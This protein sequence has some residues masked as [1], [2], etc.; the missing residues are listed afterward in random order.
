MTMSRNEMKAAM[1][2]LMNLVDG[3]YDANIEGLRGGVSCTDVI[4]QLGLIRRH[5]KTVIVLA[6]LESAEPKR[7]SLVLKR[8]NFAG[9]ENEFVIQEVHNTMEYQPGDTMTLPVVELI[10]GDPMWNVVI[11]G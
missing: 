6:E 8:Q 9:K 10:T 7:S 2:Q 1:Q 5:A 11:R 3:V 4:N